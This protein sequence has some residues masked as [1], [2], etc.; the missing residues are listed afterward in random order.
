MTK[1]VAQFVL[2]LT[3]VRMHVDETHADLDVRGWLVLHSPAA[4]AV[5]CS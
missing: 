5:I 1:H 4:V 3:Y 2:H